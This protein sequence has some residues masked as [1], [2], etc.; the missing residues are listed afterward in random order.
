MHACTPARLPACAS[1][2]APRR[3]LGDLGLDPQ[4]PIVVVDKFLFGCLI[5]LL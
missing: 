4:I 2:F 3:L 1:W 5:L